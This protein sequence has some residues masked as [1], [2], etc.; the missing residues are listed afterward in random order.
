[1]PNIARPSGLLVSMPCSMTPQL[2][3]AL[4]QLFAELHQVRYDRAER[5]RLEPR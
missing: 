3:A 4:A 1:M 2:H 5:E